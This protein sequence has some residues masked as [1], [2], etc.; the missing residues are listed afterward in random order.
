MPL[1]YRDAY[2]QKFCTPEL[3]AL[4]YA[5]VDLYDPDGNFTESWRD[6]LTVVR[7]YVLACLENQSDN[8]DLFTAKLKS[9]EKEFQGLLAQARTAAV[10]SEG[11]LAPIFSIP[12]E[13]S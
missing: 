5:D 11:N 12:L 2:L 6:K 7:A 8:E 10:D 3:E 4:A 1:T 9:Y 13:R